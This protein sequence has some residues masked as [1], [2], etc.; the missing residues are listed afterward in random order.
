MPRSQRSQRSATRLSNVA[1]LPTPL[2]LSLYGAGLLAAAALVFYFLHLLR[3]SVYLA[4]AGGLLLFA[5]SVAYGYEKMGEDKIRPQLEAANAKLEQAYTRA[6]EFRA[7]AVEAQDATVAIIKD[8]DA[9]LALV[10]KSL[11]DKINAQAATIRN[12]R[13]PGAAR[14][15][16]NSAIN[17]AERATGGPGA[18]AA[19]AAPTE[20]SV[21]PDDTTVGAIE[22]WAGQVVGLYGQCTARVAGLQSYIQKLHVASVAAQPTN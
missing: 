7:A 14:V 13:F 6:Q 9:K 22:V 2:E 15:L 8:R 18:D 4:A 16:I 1:F 10:A 11:G 20:D 3:V 21:G 12:L 19:P 5:A 17:D